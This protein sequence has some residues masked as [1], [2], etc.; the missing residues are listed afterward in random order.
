[1]AVDTWHRGSSAGGREV[2]VRIRV[3]KSIVEWWRLLACNW[4]VFLQGP[5]VGNYKLKDVVLLQINNLKYRHAKSCLFLVV[6]F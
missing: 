5:Q 2:L 4:N 6:F 3:I 1:M